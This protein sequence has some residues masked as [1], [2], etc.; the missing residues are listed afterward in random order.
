MPTSQTTRAAISVVLPDPAP[1][2]TTAGS[3]GAV[4]AANCCSLSGKSA[5]MK[6]C[7]AAGVA[8]SRG[9]SPGVDVVTTAPSPSVLAGHMAVKSQ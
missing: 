5:R 7:R 2:I 9:R 3:S 1:A 8:S 4:T 6:A